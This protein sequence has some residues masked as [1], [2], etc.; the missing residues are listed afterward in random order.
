VI[1]LCQYVNRYNKITLDDS[2]STVINVDP[3]NTV[4]IVNGKPGAL[5]DLATGM[6][7]HTIVSLQMD[8]GGIADRV[9][10]YC[11]D[12]SISYKSSVPDSAFTD[13]DGIDDTK[14][15]TA[16]NA[17]TSPTIDASTPIPGDAVTGSGSGLDPHISPE[18]A[19]LQ[20]SRVAEAR[21]LPKEKVLE[22][23][24]ANTQ[25]PDLG[26]LGDTSVNVLMLNIALDKLAP[27]AAAPI[28]APAD[29]PANAPAAK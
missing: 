5:G 28:S 22:L 19:E 14:L 8:F 25:K 15:V 3:K 10:H 18:N 6:T 7:V 27:L 16:F 26:F 4:F 2:D 23:I 17:A 20:A 21:K 29:A 11:Q 1:T 9:I 12:N 13:A 24:R